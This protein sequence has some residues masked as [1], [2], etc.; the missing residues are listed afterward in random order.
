MKDAYHIVPM[1]YDDDGFPV[2]STPLTPS[3]NPKK[4]MVLAMPDHVIPVIFIPGIMGSNLK[5]TQNISK[6]KIDAGA[7]AWRPDG[8]GLKNARLTA[9]TRQ[10]LLDPENTTVDTRI[11]VDGTSYVTPFPG[12]SLKCA[13]LRGWGGIYW[14]SY[15]G[16][17][18]YMNNT[19][20]N[21][22]FYD[23]SMDKV[24][25]NGI[26]KGL[27]DKGINSPGRPQL[28]LDANEI[29]HMSEFWYPIHAFGYNWLQ[30]N[31]I[32]GKSL[33]NEIQ[34]IKSFYQ[35]KLK[36]AAAC[37]KVI[38][39]THSMGGLV[40]RA[41]VHPNIGAADSD[42][43]GIIHGV[44]PAIGA[45]AA[46]KRMRTGFERG[47]IDW[48][49][50][51]NI[52]AEMGGQAVAGRNGRD[53]TAVLGHSPGGLQLLPNKTYHSEGWLKMGGVENN[54]YVLPMLGNPY[55]SIY[56][57][58]KKWWRLINPEWLDPAENFSTNKDRSA[59]GS[60]VAALAL[61]ENFH[62]KLGHHYH[63]NTFVF[64]GADAQLHPSYGTV[65]W[66][67]A[68][69]MHQGIFSAIPN[70]STNINL[71]KDGFA[72]I[73][74]DDAQGIVTAELNHAVLAFSM[75]KGRDAGDGTVPAISGA[76]PQRYAPACVQAQLAVTGIDH[77]GAYDTN[78]AIVMDFIAYS[79]CKI[80]KDAL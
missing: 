40:A 39:I 11:N 57:E 53:V 30:S 31:E 63:H 34:R 25:T 69:S 6:I 55:T 73:R 72:F 10:L 52:K 59:W 23:P 46:Y 5:V 37:Q 45:A 80:A 27:A 9:A 75:T 66:E 47:E 4:A 67:K 26:F 49:S 38:L 12:M 16:V 32:A 60:F 76:A 61:A 56:G 29:A 1:A 35:T 36:H 22:C 79:V 17:I 64:H 65:T 58:Q 54:P 15:G 70:A 71:M 3:Q 41:A 68:G 28:K 20:N 18:Q 2:W 50:L 8:A 77:Q 74:G 51:G 48:L 21:P 24:V 44:M 62:E 7:I 14:K 42:V 13:E 19:L 78:N 33:A 43:L